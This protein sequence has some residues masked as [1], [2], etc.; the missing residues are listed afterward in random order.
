M[1]LR[2]NLKNARISKGLTQQQVADLCDINVAMYSG[3]ETGRYRPSIDKAERIA[4]AL[5]VLDVRYIFGNDIVYPQISQTKLEEARK[6]KG[7]TMTEIAQ[8]CY[9]SAKTYSLYERGYAT[10]R[11]D[12]AIRIGELMDARTL[13]ELCELFEVGGDT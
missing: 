7:L 10:P 12:T 8:R 5:G 13:E 2:Y 9:I 4:N 1:T 6:C 11:L 3:Y